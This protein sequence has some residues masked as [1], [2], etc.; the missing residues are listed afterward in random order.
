MNL[1]LVIDNKEKFIID[2]NF[3]YRDEVK[4][5][6]NV[7]KIAQL[8]RD[9]YPNNDLDIEYNNIMNYI[10]S[11]ELTLRDFDIVDKTINKRINFKLYAEF[12]TDMY[13]GFAL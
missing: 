6:K 10:K 1:Y 12:P 9:K 2:N 11:K 8:M 7:W 13:R 3:I 5:A 4:V